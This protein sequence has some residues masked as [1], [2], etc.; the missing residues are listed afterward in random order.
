MIRTYIY[1]YV[2]FHVLRF[3]KKKIPTI[4]GVYLYLWMF[5][6]PLRRSPNYRKLRRLVLF[7]AANMILA[8]FFMYLNLN[9]CM[10]IKF[11]NCIVTFWSFLEA[12]ADLE[13]LKWGCTIKK[14]EAVIHKSKCNTPC[15]I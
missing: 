13:I 8:P 12:V 15:I 11:D 3:L 14:E 10:L 9:L 4:P 7:P 5:F 6:G 2:L 1:G